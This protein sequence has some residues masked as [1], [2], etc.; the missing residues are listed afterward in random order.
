VKGAGAASTKD[1]FTAVDQSFHL[2]TL[3]VTA[4]IVHAAV[5]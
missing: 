1:V 4:V 3:F 2:I 5:S